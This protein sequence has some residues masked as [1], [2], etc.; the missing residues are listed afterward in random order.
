M[1]YYLELGN[2]F[3]NIFDLQLVESTDAEPADTGG[4]T[5]CLKN[6]PEKN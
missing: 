4:L 6:A 1:L 5:A 2:F 3:P